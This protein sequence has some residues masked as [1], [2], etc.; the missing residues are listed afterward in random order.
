M[1]LATGTGFELHARLTRKA[2]F[3]AKMESLMPC[4]ELCALIE[5]HYPKS[6]NGRPPIG[7]ERILRMYWV[8][9]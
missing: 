4:S 7:L 3:L 9:N 8:A 6:A 5:P 2:D 1:T